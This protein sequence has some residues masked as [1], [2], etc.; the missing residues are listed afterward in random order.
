MTRTTWFEAADEAGWKAVVANRELGDCPPGE[1][2]GALRALY[3][4]GDRRLVQALTL[5]IS[6]RITRRLRRL[7]GTDHP[8]DGEDIIE[9]AHGVLLNAIFDPTSADG[10]ELIEHFWART[11]NRGID[12]ARVEGKYHHRHPALFA[13]DDGEI[14]IPADRRVDG[15]AGSIDVSHV[16]SRIRDPKKRLAF[17]LYLEGMRIRKGD[18]SIATVLGCD[19]KTAAKYIAEARAILA[20]QLEIGA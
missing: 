3:L 8:N 13:S 10:P 11:R 19:P 2:V 12:A 17:R 4:D 20:A 1:I 14:L 16:L 15:G 9:R 6:D 18:P 5:H 7:I